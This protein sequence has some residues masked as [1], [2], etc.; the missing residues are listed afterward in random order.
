MDER[1]ELLASM[2]V[3][4]G[5][6]AAT[7]QLLTGLAEPL[8]LAAGEHFFREGENSQTMYVLRAGEVEIYRSWQSNATL[9]RRM[10]PGDCFG[11]MA[12]VDLFPRSASALA[13]TAC[14]ALQIT[15]AILQEIYQHDLEQFTLLQMNLGRE[16]SRRLRE[17]DEL[18]FRTLMGETLPEAT[19]ARLV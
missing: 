1:I 16:M 19:L 10:R 6:N 18:L 8:A 12:L 11:E 4:G 14:E 7:I 5:M 13:V 2:P 17:V 9:L 3:F 15:P